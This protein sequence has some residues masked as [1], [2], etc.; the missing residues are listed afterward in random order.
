MKICLMISSASRSFSSVARR[1]DNPNRNTN[2]TT[3]K[4]YSAFQDNRGNQYS[5]ASYMEFATWFFGV[6]RRT[7]IASLSTETFR[8]LEREA[9]Q[10]AEARRRIA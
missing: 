7:L 3:A 6:S 5:F 8:K 10:S 1:N 2:M 9:S 4:K